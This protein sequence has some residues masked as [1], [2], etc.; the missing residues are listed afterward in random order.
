MIKIYILV[1]LWGGT[2]TANNGKTSLAVEFTSLPKCQA[3]AYELNKRVPTG[4]YQ[5]PVM[6]CAEK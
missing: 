5:T 6:I 4:G 2:I 1:I 3:A